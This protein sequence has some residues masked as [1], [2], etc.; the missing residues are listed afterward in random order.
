MSSVVLKDYFLDEIL[1]VI[2]EEKTITHEKISD[3]IEE[4]LK[5]NKKCK[6]PSDTNYELIDPCYPPIIQSGGVYALKPSAV[7]DENAL[8]PQAIVV[9]LGLRYKNY[10]SNV[11][12]TF[13]IDPPKSQETN[14]NFLLELQSFVIS[15]MKPGVPLK[16]IWEK[17]VEFVQTKRPDL[18]PHLVTNF[19]FGMG[20]EF[21][22]SEFLI[23]SKNNNE[24]QSNMVFNLA[25]GLQDLT[26]EESTDSKGK[27]YALLISDTVRVTPSECVVLTPELKALDEIS[28]SFNE[29]DE[30]EEEA[31][32][33]TRTRGRNEK[34]STQ[35]AVLRTKLRGQAEESKESERRAHQK[36]LARQKHEEC[37]DLYTNQNGKGDVTAKK[38]IQKFESYKK[39]IL[40][41][42]ETKDL[43]VIHSTNSRSL[44]TRE[45][46]QSYFLSM[47][48]Q[49]PFT[50]LQ[51]RT[52]VKMKKENFLIFASISILLELDLE[53]KTRLPLKITNLILSNPCHSVVPIIAM[54][55]KYF[56]K[57]MS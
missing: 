20:I 42:K 12:R 45:M 53:R 55:M 7:S 40:L 28:F 29:E 32:V 57:S 49:F 16:E 22:E 9:S 24:I 43:R 41:P 52:S 2:D 26:N 8:H 4:C 3:K 31:K 37:L 25:I 11:A 36:E 27:K 39:D 14:Y 33:E 54:L 21:R 5:P 6:F 35:T 18:E 19:G 23:N 1:S 47:E 15:E 34:A 13:L 48:F 17:G 56:V 38:V 50:W 10:C 30:E 46:K 51:S 44:L